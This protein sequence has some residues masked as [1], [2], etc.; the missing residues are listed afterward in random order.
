MVVV[1]VSL[2]TVKASSKCRRSWDIRAQGL[3]RGVCV[4]VCGT[5]LL[6]GHLSTGPSHLSGREE[7]CGEVHKQHRPWQEGRC[8]YC[9]GCGAQ[10]QPLSSGK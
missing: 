8:P 7:E 4:C 6:L 9:I 2:A 10:A 3:G 5:S 1:Q